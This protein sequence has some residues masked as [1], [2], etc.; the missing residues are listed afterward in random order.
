LLPTAKNVHKTKHSSKNK[1]LKAI[2]KFIKKESGT[3][4]QL[5]FNP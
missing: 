1:I 2:N 5:V 3:Q 4:E